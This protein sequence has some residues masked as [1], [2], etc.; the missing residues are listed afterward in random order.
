MTDPI[1]V[2]NQ[3]FIQE[4]EAVGFHFRC[5]SCAHV[6]RTAATCSLGFPNHFLRGEVV[7][8]QADG[9]MAFCKYFELGETLGDLG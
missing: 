5:G 1:A 7:A 2:A 9:E 6:Q 3:Q 8:L 4:V